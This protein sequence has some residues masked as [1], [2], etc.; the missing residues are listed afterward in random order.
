LLALG[1][2]ALLWIDGKQVLLRLIS[3]RS[4]IAS[5]TWFHNVQRALPPH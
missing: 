1:H 3:C 2:A 5:T 4:S